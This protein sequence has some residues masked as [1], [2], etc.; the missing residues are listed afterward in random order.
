[1]ISNNC[2]LQPIAMETHRR[3]VIISAL[4]SKEAGGWTFKSYTIHNNNLTEF[5]IG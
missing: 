4:F 3:G 1:M 2:I 5:E